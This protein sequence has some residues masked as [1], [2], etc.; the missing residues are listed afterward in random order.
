MIRNQAVF[1]LDSDVK[2]SGSSFEQIITIPQGHNRISLLSCQIPKTFHLFNGQTST[3]MINQVSYT[4][5]RGNYTVTQFRD[6][7]NDLGTPVQFDFSQNTGF[8]TCTS[9]SSITV[10]TSSNSVA[11][12][13]GINTNIQYT[14]PFESS[15]VVNMQALSEADINI[16]IVNTDNVSEHVNTLYRIYPTD[17]QYYGSIVFTNPQVNET[18]LRLIRPGNGQIKIKVTLLDQNGQE[19]NLH[20]VPYKLSVI[21]YDDRY[22]ENRM[23]DAIRALGRYLEHIIKFVTS[24]AR[25]DLALGPNQPSS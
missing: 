14:T 4:I 18:S 13:L 1:H 12:A 15:K 19:I 10:S 20:Q 21:T 11:Q 7:L 6:I 9:N 16:D 22:D 23:T 5:P 25:Y 17:T 24:R 8:F 3:I 2:S